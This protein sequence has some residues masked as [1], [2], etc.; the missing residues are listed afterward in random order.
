MTQITRHRQISS[1]MP[2]LLPLRNR[3]LGPHVSDIIHEISIERGLYQRRK[4]PPVQAMFEVGLAFEDMVVQRWQRT[5]PDRYMRPGEFQY[6]GI[7]FTPDMLDYS[8]SPNP[9]Y[10]NALNP[11]H[12]A[13]TTR[14]KMESLEEDNFWGMQC[15][16]KAYCFGL[17]KVLN[18]P[19]NYFV[20]HVLFLLGDYG[21]NPSGY[22][23]HLFEWDDEEL[24][25]NWDM[26]A[27]KG[28]EMEGEGYWVDKEK[29]KP[30]QYVLIPKGVEDIDKYTAGPYKVLENA[31]LHVGKEGDKIY[32]YHRQ[33]EYFEWSVELKKWVPV[34]IVI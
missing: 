20:L 32:E 3:S 34:E 1:V 28:I 22:L 6:N 23:E 31:L 8:T 27:I 25:S 11:I 18:K 12:D 33:R 21:L 15:Q 26:L 13:K 7:Y 29:N 2:E 24:E 5:Y 9:K 30:L 17:S 16:G 4:T 14:K 10:P 19:H